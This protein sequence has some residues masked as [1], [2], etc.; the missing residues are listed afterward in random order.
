M[1]RFTPFLH[2]AAGRHAKRIRAAGK[3][4]G[5]EQLPCSDRTLSDLELGHLSQQLQPSRQA[6]HRGS[7]CQGLWSQQHGYHQC[8]AASMSLSQV[9]SRQIRSET[10]P[11]SACHFSASAKGPREGHFRAGQPP[12]Q[13]SPP[14]QQ[15]AGH[16]RGGQRQDPWQQTSASVQ[17]RPSEGGPTHQSRPVTAFAPGEGLNSWLLTTPLIGTLQCS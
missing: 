10:A 5:H 9:L 16:S 7:H 8:S 13:A 17:S 14:L 3:T 1:Q 6:Q 2:R 11:A 15:P 12:R 4:Q